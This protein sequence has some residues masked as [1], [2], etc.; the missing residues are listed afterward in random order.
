MSTA[1]LHSYFRSSTSYRARIALNLK[2]VCYE[3]VPHHLRKKEHQAP[4]YLAVNP[5]GLVPAL[6]MGGKPVLTQSLAIVEYL[7]ET[8]PEPPFLPESPEDRARVRALAQMIAIEIHPLNNLRVLRAL[9]ERFG[10]DEAVIGDWFRHWVVETF[11]PLEEMLASDPRTGRFC[12]GDTPGLADICLVPQ[13]ANNARYDI[14][15]APYPTIGRINE[16]CME[17]EAFQRAAPSQ[18]PDAEA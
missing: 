7:D 2:G 15:M 16:A 3:I 10:A 5:Q 6:E 18:Q 9:R 4:E 12:H 13:V 11:A 14:D 17:L 8:I 1:I